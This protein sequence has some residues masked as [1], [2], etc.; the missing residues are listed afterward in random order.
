[1]VP[2]E[3]RKRGKKES[4][5]VD[6]SVQPPPLTD[7]ERVVDTSAQHPAVA[8]EEWVVDTSAQHSP[9]TDEE[10][11][12]F[13]R[14]SVMLRPHATETPPLRGGA[15]TPGIV[16]GAIETGAGVAGARLWGGADSEDAGAEGTP[17]QARPTAAETA[18]AALAEQQ[19]QER[20]LQEPELTGLLEG[21]DPLMLMAPDAAGGGTSLPLE[22]DDPTTAAAGAPQKAS[23]G[24]DWRDHDD[25]V[26]L[27][28][29]LHWCLRGIP[30]ESRPATVQDAV[31]GM[32]NRYSTLIGRLAALLPPR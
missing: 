3:P 30:L 32:A 26:L 28:I 15:L 24:F 18:P 25:L 13:F 2:R 19:W 12:A 14:R 29:V 8:D 11:E 27:G 7:E 16:P 10:W 22:G 5:V 20:S 6:T 4:A 9:V 1:M 17:Q 23:A 21:D 31:W